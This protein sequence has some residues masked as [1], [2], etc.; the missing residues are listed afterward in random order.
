M[1][2]PAST[3]T[4]Q[5]W[6]ADVDRQATVLRSQAEAQSARSAAGTLTMDDVRRFFDLLVQSAV[7]FNSAA[8][9]PGIGAYLN[10]E[11]QGGVANPVGEF[12]AMRAQVVGTLDWLRANVPGGAFTGADGAQTY[13]L[14]FTFPASNTDPAVPLRYTAAQTAGYRTALAALVATVG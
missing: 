11:K 9:V 1:A 4:L 6:V 12:N 8:A 2:Y 3:K 13:K 14:A 5:Q 7:L 10:D